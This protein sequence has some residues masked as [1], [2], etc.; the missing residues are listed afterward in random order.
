MTCL[1]GN[2]SRYKI[3]YW[4]LV[5][6]TVSEASVSLI[7]AISIKGTVQYFLVLYVSCQHNVYDED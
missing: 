1:Q 5:N 6:F 4:V 3:F 7:F 2:G